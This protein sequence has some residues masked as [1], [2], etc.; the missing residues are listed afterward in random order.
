MPT[1][2]SATFSQSVRLPSRVILPDAVPVP[3]ALCTTDATAGVTAGEAVGTASGV[4][5]GSA[6]GTGV[7]CC[8]L[9]ASPVDTVSNCSATFSIARTGVVKRLMLNGNSKKK[10]TI[11]LMFLLFI[12]LA[13]SLKPFQSDPF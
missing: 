6:D 3:K 1:E 12:F 9:S 11:F 5:V 8:T 13:P 2:I 4:A 10:L 7:A